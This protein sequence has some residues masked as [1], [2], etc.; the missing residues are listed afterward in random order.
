MDGISELL[1]IQFMF[2]VTIAYYLLHWFCI[3]LPLAFRVCITYTY[4]QYIWNFFLVL[5][6]FFS[7]YL[8]LSLSLSHCLVFSIIIIEF[9]RL[10]AFHIASGLKLI[11]Q[12]LCPVFDI[13]DFQPPL[14][15]ISYTKKF[16]DLISVFC[17]CALLYNIFIFLIENSVNL[18]YCYVWC[19]LFKKIQNRENY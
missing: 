6:I 5:V 13:F 9:G 12:L 2:L 11:G 8:S 10:L 16:K 7:F 3:L 18:F 1:Y 4:Q 15:C 17:V 19:K 14:I